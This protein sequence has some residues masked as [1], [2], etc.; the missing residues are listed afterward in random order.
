SLLLSWVPINCDP[1]TLVAGVMREPFWRFLVLVT[2]AKW[3]RYG[4]LAMLT[5]HWI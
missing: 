5:L 4:G 2:Q 1:L 3:A